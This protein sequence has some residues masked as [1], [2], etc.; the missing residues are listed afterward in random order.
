[1]RINRLI[2]GPALV[3]LAVTAAR[4]A[5]ELLHGPRVLFNPDPGG[6]WAVVGI[7]WL[8]PVF[9]VYFGLKLAA[10]D[11]QPK[12]LGRAVG[13]ALL[14]ASA[15]FVFCFVG[16]VLHLQ[17]DFHGR[18]LYAW[19]VVALASLVTLYGWPELFRTL[20]AYAFAARVPVVAVMLLA[21]GKDWGTHYDAVPPDLP[22]GLGALAKFLWLGFFPQLIFWV[23]ITVLG[24]MLFGSLAAG[25]AHLARANKRCNLDG[26]VERRSTFDPQFP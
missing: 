6:P 1:V 11:H 3:T 12:S 16:S 13:F 14:G 22:E 10:R 9:G 19:T 23:G 25:I 2:L 4:L 21:F 5:G 18:L 24:G 15:L 8:A 26:G 7:I 17:H 20:L